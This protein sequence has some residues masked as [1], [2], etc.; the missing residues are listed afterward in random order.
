M[1]LNQPPLDL[2]QMTQGD[3][4]SLL[5]Y[6]FYLQPHLCLFSWEYDLFTFRESFLKQGIDYWV[7]HPFPHL[8][9]GKNFRFVL[10]RNAKNNISWR[11]VTEGEYLLLERF[12]VGSSLE[13]ACEY[14]ENQDDA[15]YEQ[16][17]THLQKW[18][19]EWTQAGWLTLSNS[20]SEK[21]HV[22][23]LKHIVD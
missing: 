20:E 19:Q 5:S 2:I 21:D 15:L 22:F 8:S 11:E 1:G 13:A 4:E 12:K 3:P 7:E 10:Y 16:V 14:I 23:S 18:I 17:A 9:K 6:T